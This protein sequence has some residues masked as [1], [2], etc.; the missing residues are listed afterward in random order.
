MKS[1]LGGSMEP[2]LL[3]VFSA[4]CGAGIMAFKGR[5]VPVGLVLGALVPVVAPLILLA[6]PKRSSTRPANAVSEAVESFPQRWAS[7]AD[8]SPTVTGRPLPPPSRGVVRLTASWAGQEVVGESKYL[9]AL[10]RICRAAGPD[11]VVTAIARF[12]AEPDNR[13]DAQAIRVSIDGDTVG[14][15]PKAETARLH[16]LLAYLRSR[17][18]AAE[19]QARVWSGQTYGG[20]N[21]TASVQLAIPDDLSSA[22][23]VDE[24]PAG[25]VLWPDGG[26]VQV[27]DE[28]S[29]LEAI[30]PILARGYMP[31]PVKA[32]FC[33]T[34]NLSDKGKWQVTVTTADGAV[35]G[36]LSAQMATK[37]GPVVSRISA[38][39]RCVALGVAKGNTAA[40]EIVLSMVSPE[41][42][43]QTDVL[44]M[45]L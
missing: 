38:P 26:R 23:A 24:M 12:E 10:K 11:G 5:S 27:V 30:A 6:L 17:G 33:L 1:L 43:D 42:L 19:C 37:F 16:P 9:P 28:A 31:G 7:K 4:A 8:P 21:W 14:Y 41:D 15:I 29:H 39:R 35:V 13:Y 3:I 40:A 2:F 18:L 44:R 34:A 36:G 22:V 45:G 32:H 20:D 25:G